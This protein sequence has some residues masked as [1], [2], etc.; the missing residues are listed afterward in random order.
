MNKFFSNH[1]GTIFL[2]FI[3]LFMGI[4]G[5][6]SFDKAFPDPTM[7]SQEIMKGLMIEAFKDSEVKETLVDIIHTENKV[8]SDKLDVLYYDSADNWV[9]AID[10]QYGKLESNASNLYWIDVEYILSKWPMMPDD[11]RTPA[12]ISKMAFIQSEYDKH[13]GNGH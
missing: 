2:M 10:K 6:S 3:G 4:V 5:T 13:I 11:Y 1:A 8:V 7:I 12:L 9:R